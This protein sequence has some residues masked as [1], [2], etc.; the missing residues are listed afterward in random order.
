MNNTFEKQ[1]LLQQAKQDDVFNAADFW[2][3]GMPKLESAVKGDKLVPPLSLD[4]SFAASDAPSGGQKLGDS[5]QGLSQLKPK[6]GLKVLKNDDGS[7]DF[8]GAGTSFTVQANGDVTERVNG[9]AKTV[10]TASTDKD[11]NIVVEKNGVSR[12]VFKDGTVEQSYKMDWEDED[13]VPITRTNHADGLKKTLKVE[14]KDKTISTDEY[15]AVPK[16]AVETNGMSVKF[17]PQD[18]SVTISNGSTS[19]TADQNGDLKVTKDG[20]TE[21]FKALDAKF[22]PSGLRCGGGTY[23]FPDGSSIYFK[24]GHVG[25]LSVPDGN[26]GSVAGG[27]PIDSRMRQAEIIVTKKK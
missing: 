14:L 10:G 17:V 1:D 16:D 3:A 18:G 22:K 8:T 20:K 26:G 7:F 19:W 2:S 13:D 23:T 12:K 4:H 24:N 9:K 21:T 25:S 27:Y 6:N 11:G 15:A 5:M